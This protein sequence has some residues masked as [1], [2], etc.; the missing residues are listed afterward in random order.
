M[1]KKKDPIKPIEEPASELLQAKDQL[2]T[3]AKKENKI[4][5]REILD[6]IPDKPE[7]VELLDSLYTELADLIIEVTAI[8]PGT[9]AFDSECDTEE[10]EEET[11]ISDQTYLD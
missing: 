11:T 10:A 9:S 3:K 1:A 8:E 7:N 6:L 2:L 4:D 5:Q